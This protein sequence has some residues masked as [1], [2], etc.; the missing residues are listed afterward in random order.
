MKW[1]TVFTLIFVGLLI[2]LPLQALPAGTL[3]KPEESSDP[4]SQKEE[5][6]APPRTD[7]VFSVWDSKA[8]KVVSMNEWD[9]IFYTVAAEMPVD[10]GEEAL[11]AQTV[12][13]YTY[14]CRQRLSQKKSPSAALHGADFADVPSCF[15]DGYTDDYLKEKWGNRYTECRRTLEKAV[16]AVFGQTLTYEGELILAAYHAISCGNTEAASVVW[17]TDYPYLKSVPCPGDTLA[18]GYETTAR[19]TA[20]ELAAALSE[21]NGVSLSGTADGWMGNISHSAAGTVTSMEIGGQTLTG[22]QVRK[23][24]GL[25]S[26][27]FTAAYTNG[28]FLFTVRGFGHGVGMSQYGAG[29]L[30]RQGMSYAEILKYFYT[31]AELSV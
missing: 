19:F 10:Y 22:R 5:S 13:S 27:S 9:F 7:A 29:Y 18:E 30:A 31:G 14:F 24:L 23:L 2:A 4:E 15:P 1:S 21:V 20:A 11:K 3:P 6:F 17:N 28:S 26:A 25:R 12:A 8:E 16:N